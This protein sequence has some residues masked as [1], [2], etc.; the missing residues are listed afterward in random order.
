MIKKDVSE[1]KKQFKLDNPNMSLDKVYL[2]Y[3]KS[4]GTVITIKSREFDMLT[5]DEKTLYFTNHKKVL[6]GALGSKLY[7]LPMTTASEQ[8]QMLRNAYLD[9]SEENVKAII[10]AIADTKTYSGDIVIA[11]THGQYYKP[12]K[13][14]KDGIEDD[15]YPLYRFIIGSVNP[16]EPSKNLFKFDSVE[17]DMKLES[18]LDKNINFN[19]PFDG[20]LYPAY[21]DLSEDANNVL[22]YSKSTNEPNMFFVENVL[23][24][25][26]ELTAIREKDCFKAIINEVVGT[27]VAVE[28][29]EKVY[30][31]LSEMI[32]KNTDSQAPTVGKGELKKILERSGVKNVDKVDEC[33]FKIVGDDKTQL[34]VTSIVPE[35]KIKITSPEV[36]VSIT[37]RSLEKVKHII[38]KEGKKCLVIEIDD[39]LVI[40]GIKLATKN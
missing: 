17:Q 16:V 20:F 8:Q 1:I 6:T 31:N 36:N 10:E 29:M 11:I 40:E 4:D 25:K 22:Y 24:S 13:T 21:N 3:I 12:V 9:F 27:E 35:S 28:V 37:Q 2:A 32:E 34:K 38:N 33:Y 26:V 7:E 19:S 5:E 15:E 18:S 14:N 23:G 30:S 39:D